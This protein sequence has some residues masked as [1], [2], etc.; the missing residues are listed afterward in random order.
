MIFFAYLGQTSN[1]IEY[2]IF[3]F[4]VFILESREEVMKSK[5]IILLFLILLVVIF[6]VGVVSIKFVKEK[7]AKFRVSLFL[8][9]RFLKNN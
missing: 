2:K 1:R 7:K 9:R 8:K 6:I 5:K 4:K 3:Y